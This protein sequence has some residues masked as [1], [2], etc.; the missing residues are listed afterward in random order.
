SNSI[1]NNS[2]LSSSSSVSSLSKIPPLSTFY[3]SNEQL[4]NRVDSLLQENH[5]LKIELDMYK[6]RLKSTLSNIENLKKSTF[7]K[8]LESEQEEEYRSNILFKQI[9]EL[10]LDI[11]NEKQQ[12]QNTSMITSDKGQNQQLQEDDVKKLLKQEQE[13]LVVKLS[14][15]IK[16]LEADMKQKQQQLDYLQHDKCNLENKLEQN[17]EKLVN[18]LIKQL[19]KLEIE[20]HLLQDKLNEKYGEPTTMSCSS[21]S[22]LIVDDSV[23]V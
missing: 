19:N 18:K 15:K 11:Q 1:D 22:S 23:P 8:H 2:K 17:E 10:N 3:S 21:C 20:K 4:Q 16:Y 14:S 6:L 5:V 12:Q 7:I 9:N 13:E